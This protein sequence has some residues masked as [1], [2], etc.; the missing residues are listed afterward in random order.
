METARETPTTAGWA[1]KKT[2]RTGRRDLQ[3][4][5]LLPITDGVILLA[6][7]PTTR[8]AASILTANQLDQS[9]ATI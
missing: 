2:I 3:R 9:F 8:L 4:Q 7:L 5:G 1:R 6:R